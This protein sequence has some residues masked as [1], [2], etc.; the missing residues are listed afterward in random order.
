MRVEALGHAS[1]LV[2]GGIASVLFDPL[3]FGEHQDG[4]YDVYP[5]RALD[6]GSLPEVSAL[7]VSH[8]HAD[9]FDP[10]SLAFFP[11]D[12]PVIAA[13]DPLL[14]GCLEGL[15][16]E[17]ILR[18][19]NHVPIQ[20][21]DLSVTPT[22]ASPGAPEHGFLVRHEDVTLWNMVDTFPEPDDIATVLEGLAKV[23]LLIA[24]WQPLRDS[25]LSAGE[26]IQF[27]YEMYTQILQQIAQIKPEMLALGAAG[28]RARGAAAFT[29][30]LMF[31]VTRE[32]FIRDI[33][34]MVPALT[35]ACLTLDP[36]DALTL[37]P[38][39]VSV[40]KG[41]LP[42][43]RTLE[44]Y[45]DREL[46]FRPFELGF[47]V[48]ETR[49]SGFKRAECFEAVDAFFEQSLLDCVRDRARKFDLHHRFQVIREYEVV[50]HGGDRAHWV[51]DF[52]G[53][54]C[55][56]RRGGDPLATAHT[57]LPAS[58]LVGLIAGTIT[59]DYAVL[60]AELR[61]YD[62]TYLSNP[63]GVSRPRPGAL[64]DPL[65]LVFGTQ[66]AKEYALALALERVQKD[67]QEASAAAATLPPPPVPA[68][69]DAVKVLDPSVIAM[70][71]FQKL[72]R[73]MPAERLDPRSESNP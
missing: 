64:F 40:E 21:G 66:R 51:L 34:Q 61:R 25:A 24:P 63:G 31:P 37:G 29:N 30:H 68:E 73:P 70:D 13:D 35:T 10:D 55:E 11:K 41:L 39:L 53:P 69:T 62:Q 56:L 12:M 52:S 9:H 33:S 19:Q 2:R 14:V 47:E 38:Q 8:L 22:P 7:I 59:W 60:S 58:L 44:P 1:W 20:V 5:P 46:A 67:W 32:R 36:G 71:V 54:R 6:L 48:K 28:F 18:A 65:V 16:F 26:P 49:G 17:H 23:D 72:G 4:L 50:F 57:V 3:L 45:D 15:G 42:Y 27:P 43:C